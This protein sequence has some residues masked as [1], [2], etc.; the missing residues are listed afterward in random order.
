MLS[1]F[2]KTP[3]ISLRCKL[4]PVQYR[5][6]E[7]GSIDGAIAENSNIKVITPNIHVVLLS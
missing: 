4:A 6:Y 5:Q 7:Y 1:P 2:E 3:R